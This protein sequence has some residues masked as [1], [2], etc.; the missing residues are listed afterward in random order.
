[1]RPGLGDQEWS[2][3]WRGPDEAG[4]YMMKISGCPTL[5]K[6]T[7]TSF[8]VH[9]ILRSRAIFDQ[10]FQK[11]CLLS[12]IDFD[13][14]LGPCF[15]IF[16]GPGPLSGGRPPSRD[17]F[18]P[19]LLLSASKFRFEK[20]RS[21]PVVW[22]GAPRV[23]QQKWCGCPASWKKFW[24]GFWW[25]GFLVFLVVVSMRVFSASLFTPLKINMERNHRDLEDHFPFQMGDL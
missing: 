10:L 9:C 1:M 3:V 8:N 20:P 22:F 6:M 23:P 15:D 24:R 2:G 21:F 25:V 5:G 7:A 14:P 11:S 17:Q 16:W 18:Q 13:S 12:R 19:Q 4:W